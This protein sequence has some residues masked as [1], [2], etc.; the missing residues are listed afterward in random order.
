MQREE[1]ETGGGDEMQ[2]WADRDSHAKVGPRVRKQHEE[3]EKGETMCRLKNERSS[4]PGD[5]NI[6]RKS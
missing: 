4:D 5:Q 3:E 2:E 1:E 6:T